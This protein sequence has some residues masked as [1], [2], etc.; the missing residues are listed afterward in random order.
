VQ[1]LVKSAR[2]LLHVHTQVGA[3]TAFTIYLPARRKD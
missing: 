1:R 3:G 2:G